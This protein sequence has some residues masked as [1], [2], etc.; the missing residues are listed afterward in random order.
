MFCLFGFAL[1]SY[2]AVVFEDNFD[3]QANWEKGKP[4][5]EVD[6]GPWPAPGAPTN[7]ST[8]RAAPWYTAVT[9]PVSITNAVNSDHTTGSGKAFKAVTQSG[10]PNIFGTA[11]NSDTILAK[12]FPQEYQE[13]YVRFWLKTQPGWQYTI[14]QSNYNK[15]FRLFRYDGTGN[16]F[17]AFSGGSQAPIMLFQLSSNW[18]AANAKYSILGRGY[19]IPTNYNSATFTNQEVDM[20]FGTGAST[21][22]GSWADGGWHRYDFHAKLNTTGSANG[23][24]EMFYDG[25]KKFSATNANFKLSGSNSIG[26]NAIDLGGNSQTNFGTV[27]TAS[28]EQWYAIDDVVVSTT[29][30][31]DNYVIGGGAV[32]DTT[33][34]AVSISSPA[35]NTT[36]SGAVSI[37]ANASDAVGVSKVE[38]YVNNVLKSTDTSAPYAY[39]WDTAAVAA[40]TYTLMAKAYDAAGNVGQSSSVSVSIYKD[41]TVPTVSLTSPANNATVSGTV[42]ITANAADNIGVSKVEF[43]RNGT[44]LAA[45]NVAPYS[46]NWN[47]TSVANGAYSLTAKAFDA[48]NNVA[49]S[50]TVTVTV[51]NVT[52]DTTAPA[53][54]ITSPAA[55]ATVSGSVNIAASA[56][57]NVGVSKVEFYVNGALKGT[58]TASPYYYSWSTTA[59]ANGAYSLTSKAYD[60]AGNVSQSPTVSVN[61]NNST[62]DTTAPVVSMSSPLANSTVS[63]TVNIAASAS[64][65]V[66]VTKVEYY[67]NGGL[68]R[69]L[70]AAPFSYSVPT[71]KNATHTLYAK[72]YDAA[73]NMKQ[74]STISFTVNNSTADTTAPATSI[75]SPAAGAAVSGSVTIAAS[76]SDNVGVSKVE[77]YVNGALKGTVTASPYSYSWSTTSVANGAYSLTSKAYDAAGNVSQ[78]PAVS[79]NVNNPDTTAPVVSMSSPLA[80]STVSGTVNIAASASDNVAVTK[81]EYYLNGLLHRSLTAAPFSYSVPTTKNATHT[82]YAIAYDAAGNK[83]QSSTISFTVKNY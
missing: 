21:A 75:T 60:A 7:W 50:A 13:L 82:L 69:S 22:S 64:D 6:Y 59:V 52:A 51:N 56:S 68:H 79:V 47:T 73:G 30:I 54:S 41:T 58:G 11:Y 42:A 27:G 28:G 12:V 25:V 31:P 29:P 61:V 49:T 48:S 36:V 19:P 5:S 83:K 10:G 70:T 39:S 2:G 9:S 23:V 67:L 14:N 20:S 34:P 77:F 63:G 74:S 66:A 3:A 17:E 62:A 4:A 26:W 16:I 35:N 55:G 24:V 57:D 43:Y 71:T 1:P 40:G 65:N 32:A 53:T 18:N 72:A 80:N 15:I 44:L 8:W 33:A 45:G 81:V 46:Y 38:F 76:A 37:T 78:S